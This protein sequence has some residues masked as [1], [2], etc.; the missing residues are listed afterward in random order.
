MVK[1]SDYLEIGL[2]PYNPKCVE[3]FSMFEDKFFNHLIAARIARVDKKVLFVPL[4]DPQF[5]LRAGRTEFISQSLQQIHFSRI[6]VPNF[7]S[8]Q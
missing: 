2:K 8:L 1:N 6:G 7:Q 3:M 4:I 5:A